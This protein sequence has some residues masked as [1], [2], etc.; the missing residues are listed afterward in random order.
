[1]DTLLRNRGVFRV[2]VCGQEE[3]EQLSR[4]GSHYSLSTGILPSLGARSNR[5]VKLNRFIISPYD[6]RYRWSCLLKS[7]F[8]SWSQDFDW[9]FSSSFL[10]AMYMLQWCLVGFYSNLLVY[11]F[12]Y[13]EMWKTTPLIGLVTFCEWLL[14]LG[15]SGLIKVSFAFV[16][17]S[18]L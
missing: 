11:L 3:L 17:R 13:K 4:D 16:C 7:C 15:R 9:F 18:F 10:L 8:L 1:M 5:R 12:L 14:L 6:R 2:S